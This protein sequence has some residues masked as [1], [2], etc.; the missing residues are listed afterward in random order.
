MIFYSLGNFIFDTDYQRL[1]KYTEYGVFVKLYFE[2]DFFTWDYKAIEIDRK[3]QTIHQ[4]EAPD[5]FTNVSPLQYALLWPLA[6]RNQYKN[7]LVKFSYLYPEVKSYSKWQWFKFY[8][9][10]GKISARNKGV[11]SGNLLYCLNLW[12]FGDKKL[13]KYIKEGTK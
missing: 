7:E 13:I 9:K 4:T 6:M 12:R 11:I 10:R 8:L 3:T 5:I 2:K 1:Q